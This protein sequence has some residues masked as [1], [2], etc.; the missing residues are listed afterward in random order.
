MA[1]RHC[2]ELGYHRSTALRRQTDPLTAE[3]SKRCFWVAYDIDRVAAFILG[4]PVGISDSAIDAELP[5]DLDD[6]DVL[7][8]SCLPQTEQVARNQTTDPATAMTG[9]IHAVKLRRLWSKIIDTVYHHRHHA[10]SPAAAMAGCTR[11]Q[12]L[13]SSLRG[14][15]DQWHASTPYFM[16]FSSPQPLSVFA[17]REWFQLAYDHTILILNRPYLS[18]PIEQDGVEQAVEECCR[19]A[20]EVC[21]LYRRLYQNPTIQFTWGSLHILFLAGLT[22]LYCIWR[23]PRTKAAVGLRDVMSTSMACNTVLVIIAERWSQATTYRDLFE[24]L[25]ER[26]I[27]MVCGEAPAAPRERASSKPHHGSPVRRDTRGEQHQNG[28]TEA[29]EA[30]QNSS[31]RSSSSHGHE[32]FDL[33]ILDMAGM[34]MDVPQESEWLIQGL[35]QDMKDFGPTVGDALS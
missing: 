25:S 23:S 1:I 34:S 12:E 26:T 13:I 9:F 24:S 5:L 20:R 7:Q 14:E 28:T 31:G 3:I 32:L 21:L 19:R 4:R 22:F 10:Q 6:D 2:I 15:I 17:S 16:D 11:Q 18:L 30:R 33:G 27:S 35:L 8:L 29:Q